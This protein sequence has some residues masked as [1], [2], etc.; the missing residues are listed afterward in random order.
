MKGR[1]RRRYIALSLL[2]LAL[3]CSSLACAPKR[4]GPTASS[5]YFFTILT[6]PAVLREEGGT[7]V[8]EVRDAQGRP[9]DGVRVEFEVEPSWAQNASVSPTQAVTQQGKVQAFFQANEIG[10]VRVTVRVDGS[11]EDIRYSVSLRGTPSGS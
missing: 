5:G 1:D 7:L 8:V 11:A 3:L 9:V 4:V 6:T 2:C 10:L